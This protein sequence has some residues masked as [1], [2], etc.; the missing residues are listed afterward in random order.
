[1][2]M[3]WKRLLLGILLLVF[4]VAAIDIQEDTGSGEGSCLIAFVI[5]LFDLFVGVFY[6][7][8]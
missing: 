6:P 8:Y 4:E 2:V 7:T 3:F 5:Y 1:M